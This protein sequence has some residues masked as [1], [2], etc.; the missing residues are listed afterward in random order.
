V[1]EDQGGRKKGATFL[2]RGKIRKKEGGSSA[3]CH[4]PRKRWL[5]FFL[6]GIL[7]GEDKGRLSRAHRFDRKGEEGEGECTA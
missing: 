3:N 5:L 4:Y 2:A 7:E 6:P 1:G